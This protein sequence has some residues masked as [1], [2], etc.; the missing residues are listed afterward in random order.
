[1]MKRKR[2]NLGHIELSLGVS[3]GRSE[4]QPK[5]VAGPEPALAMDYRSASEACQ[6][7]HLPARVVRR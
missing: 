1:V 4:S 6:W 2:P 7:G 3:T 5:P